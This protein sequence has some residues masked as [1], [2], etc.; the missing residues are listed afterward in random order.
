M[1]SYKLKARQHG[2]AAVEFA[3][4]AGVF[5]TLLFGIMEMGRLMFYW[6]TATEATRLGARVAVVCSMN[7]DIIKNKMTSLFP[8]IARDEIEIRY[9]PDGCSQTTCQEVTVQIQTSS[10]IQTY[11][12]F[13][14][15]RLS[16]PPF[17]TTLP[18]E[19]LAS[20]S[21]PVCRP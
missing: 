1:N 12:P 8:V 14:P 3:L 7:D 18:R 21:N 13:V 9:S 19:S 6:N 17:L 11:I 5:F 4:I 16:L 20:A 10:V 15:L 2:V